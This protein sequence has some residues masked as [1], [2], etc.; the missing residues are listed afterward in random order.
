MYIFLKNPSPPLLMNIFP[1]EN[2]YLI[3]LWVYSLN[4]DKQM[5]YKG[6]KYEKELEKLAFR[7]SNFYFFPQIFINHSL[8]K[9]TP[10]F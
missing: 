7:C 6:G 10:E 5:S 9:F 2:V 3:F 4:W 1:P 8:I